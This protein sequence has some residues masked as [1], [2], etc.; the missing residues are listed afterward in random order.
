VSAWTSGFSMSIPIPAGTSTGLPS[1]KT[2]RCAWTWYWRNSAFSGISPAAQVS[3][4]GSP[5]ALH[6]AFVSR[7]AATSPNWAQTPDLSLV[8]EPSLLLLPPQPA[9]RTRSSAQIADAR[10]A[11]EQP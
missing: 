8:L 9:A 11:M 5:G 7:G 4:I 10:S 6:G 1:T 2:S 3:A